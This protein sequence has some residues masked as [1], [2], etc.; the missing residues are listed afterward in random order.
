[1]VNGLNFTDK[2][3]YFGQIMPQ[4]STQ[5]RRDRRFGFLHFIIYI[6]AKKIF[7]N[8]FDFF[9]KKVLTKR[10]VSDIIGKLSRKREQK[11]ET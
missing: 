1:M 9:S 8:F 7:S 5:N 3:R 2:N 10:F 4:K 6:G 11:I